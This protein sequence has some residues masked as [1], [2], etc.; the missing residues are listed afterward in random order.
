MLKYFAQLN[1]PCQFYYKQI[2]RFHNL[3]TVSSIVEY[4][5]QGDAVVSLLGRWPSTNKR[6]L[7]NNYIVQHLHSF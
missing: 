5:L 2:I 4:F 1:I 7:L 6:V 3:P